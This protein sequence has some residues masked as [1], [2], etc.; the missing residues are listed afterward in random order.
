[1]MEEHK[2]SPKDVLAKLIADNPKASKDDL[3]AAV[4]ELVGRDEGLQRA[5]FDEVFDELGPEGIASLLR[6]SERSTR[7]ARPSH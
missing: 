4:R 6:R 1:M 7:D 2:A 5:I 3:Y